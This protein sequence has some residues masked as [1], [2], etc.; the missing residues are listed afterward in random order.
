M[1]L[2]WLKRDCVMGEVRCTKCSKEDTLELRVRFVVLQLLTNCCAE[3]TA[4]F[5][6][7]QASGQSRKTINRGEIAISGTI[8]MLLHSQCFFQFFPNIYPFSGIRML[9]PYLLFSWNFTGEF[10]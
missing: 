3:L 4:G 6:I 10:K 9:S 8:L 2:S 5:E 7:S 1:L